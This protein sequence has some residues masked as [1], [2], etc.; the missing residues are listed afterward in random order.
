MC[1]RD[2][3]DST[4][5]RNTS[6]RLPSLSSGT[7][8]EVDDILCGLS[9]S[10]VPSSLCSLTGALRLGRGPTREVDEH[11]DGKGC[12]QDRDELRGREHA[13]RAALV[14]AEELDDETRDGVQQHVQP[15]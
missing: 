5:V 8:N 12:E 6:R 13:D 14:A 10:S 11:D 9:L 1:D 4:E 2:W 3:P 15:E 7:V